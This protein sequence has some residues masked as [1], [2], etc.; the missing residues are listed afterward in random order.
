MSGFLYVMILIISN[1]YDKSTTNVLG[2]LDFYN[3]KWLR[4]ND[5]QIQVLFKGDDILFELEKESFLLNE[6]TSC[7]YRRGY[8]NYDFSNLFLNQDSLKRLQLADL[9]K[10]TEFIYYLFKQKRT[11]NTFENSDVNKLIVSC[12]ARKTGLLT[13]NDFLFSKKKSLSCL[14]KQ[15]K[16]ITKPIS[17]DSIQRFD[18]LSIFNYTSLLDINQIENEDFFPSLVQNYI[19]KKYELRIFYLDG[20][21]Y[22]MAIFSQK[23]NQTSVDFRVYNDKKPNR[24]VPFKLPKE[25]EKKLDLLMK[26]LNLNCGSIDMIVTPEN[27]YIFLEVNPVGQ[28][29]MVSYPCNYNLEKIIAEYL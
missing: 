27:E 9:E 13:P 10:I 3:K 4:I 7:W 22:S 28:F 19:E 14:T 2:W 24:N 25:I 29:G 12:E 26:K 20:F 8:I 11:I 16:Y 1:N 17:G 23:D 5:E 18:N 6:V 15:E 21:F